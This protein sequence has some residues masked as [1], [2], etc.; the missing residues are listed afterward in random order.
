[1]RNRTY[2]LQGWRLTITAMSDAAG[3]LARALIATHGDGAVL[4]AQEA[5][6]NVRA[7][8]MEDRV[9]EWERVIALITDFQKTAA[10]ANDQSSS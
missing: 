4:F 3:S 8:A 1:M 9:T 5:M 7:L 6:R 2:A 10:R